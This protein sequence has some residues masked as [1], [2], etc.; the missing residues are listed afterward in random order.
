M[1]VATGMGD[2]VVPEPTVV[3]AEDLKVLQ[4]KMVSLPV[5]AVWVV[6]E[7]TAMKEQEAS[8]AHPEIVGLLAESSFITDWSNN[9][10]L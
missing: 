9:Q 8:M 2:P 5:A 4:F 10:N 6:E 7:L 3:L 1:E